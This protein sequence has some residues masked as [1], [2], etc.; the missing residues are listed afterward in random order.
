VTT[1]GKLLVPITRAGRGTEI[2]N[3][4]KWES[5]PNK[6]PLFSYWNFWTF[7][8]FMCKKMGL[9]ENGRGCVRGVWLHCGGAIGMGR[10]V[11]PVTGRADGLS[12]D[13]AG[14]S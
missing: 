11:T 4:H 14:S 6:A 2:E 3:I 5:N 9:K 10:L 7:P 8:S 12:R 13:G 1:D